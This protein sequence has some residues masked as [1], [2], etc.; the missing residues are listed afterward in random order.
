MAGASTSFPPGAMVPGALPGRD[1]PLDVRRIGVGDVK[2]ALA[3][4]WRDF[5][6]TP[7]HLIFLA[8]I[9][10]IIGFFL[11]RA[12]SGGELLPL[13][14]PLVAGFALVGPVAALGIYELSRRRER[15][16]DVS[17]LNAFDVFRSPSIGP[18]LVLGVALLAIFVAWVATARAIYLSTVG[19]AGPGSTSDLLRLTCGTPEG[20]RLL[21]IGNA[22]GFLFALVVLA[23]TVVSFPLLLDRNVGLAH[24]VGTSV[25][26][27]ARNPAPM[28]LW[29]VAVAVLLFLGSLP[30]FVGLAVVLPML[31]HATWHLYRRVV[32]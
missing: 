7:T 26:V 4:G 5:L 24:A 18:I 21:L 8:A 16:E 30:A 28:A 31:G 29:G 15:G 9:Y 25:R 3:S 13:L 23:M 20:M 12:A 10:P 17:V 22:A 32:A 14:W 27:V 11:A 6:Q 2:E 19:A 1:M